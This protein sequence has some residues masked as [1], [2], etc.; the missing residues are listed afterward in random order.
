VN[1][2]ETLLF[3]GSLLLVLSVFAS[4]VTGKFGVPSLL[5][6]LVVGMLAGSEGIGGIYFDNAFYSQT[7]GIVALTYI[8][9]SG[10]LDTEWR[11]IR[12]VLNQGLSLATVGVLCTCVLTG[13]FTKFLLGF[14]W[15]EGFLVGAI[16]SSTD[17]AA[18][19]SVLRAK[20]VN[21][22]GQIK[23]LLELE[24]GSN[25]PMSVF[26]TTAFLHLIQ[27]KD[28]SLLTLITSF[29]HQMILGAA[30]GV[31]TGK[32]AALALSRVK[33][34]FDGLYPV[35][36]L[37]LVLLIYTTTQWVGGNGFLAV[38]LAGLILGNQNFLHKKSLILFHDGIA[39]LMQIT[40][41][42]ALG[43]FVFPSRLLP[44]AGVGFLLSLFLILAARPLSVYLSLS[45]SKLN[46]R[47]KT[48][49]SWVGLRGAVPVVLAIFPLLAGIEK[50]D[51][52]FNMVFFV[53]LT[54]ILIQGT[55]V[56]L[57]AKLLRVDAPL[58]AKFRYPIEYVPIGNMKSNLVEIIVPAS[59]LAGGKS[60]IDL[61]LPKEALIVLIQRKGD[62]IVPKGS[63][64]L[65][66]NDT[67]LVLAEDEPLSRIRQIV[68][69]GVNS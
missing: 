53:V 13:V 14:S 19:F 28:L 37:A 42:L 5:V 66:G 22:K 33:L 10:G 39:W 3:G 59:S 68:N 58:V 57:V 34:G 32:G 30:L 20:S 15:V 49:I 54:S 31:V 29:F 52:I 50:A 65:E 6:F 51:L 64:H 1:A 27:Q 43:L 16:V 7:L 62:I 40:I 11:M 55:S 46:F 45:F 47:E 26:L 2:V 4:N 36:T 44:V 35:F 12:P 60:I 18:V 38:Y 63:T 24:S 9:F 25:D 41:F 69:E 48:L 56:S 21:L 61:K 67:M 8:L 17:A 23:P